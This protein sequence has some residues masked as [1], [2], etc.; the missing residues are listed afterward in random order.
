MSYNYLK[1]LTCA[2][3]VL[4]GAQDCPPLHRRVQGA[5]VGDRDLVGTS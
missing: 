2:V 5:D 1:P 3:E 4:G